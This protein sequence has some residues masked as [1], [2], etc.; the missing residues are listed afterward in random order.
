[1]DSR[2]LLDTTKEHWCE[3][4]IGRFGTNHWLFQVANG[5]LL[6]SYL[7]FGILWLRA[8]LI[9]ASIAFIGWAI[10]ILDIALDTVL[11]NALLG[12]INIILA[13]PLFL[14]LIPTRLSPF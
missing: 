7:Q 2:F 13:I 14:A 4:V 10:W 6:F 12:V 1:M 3:D 11:W 8:T 5:L 9:L